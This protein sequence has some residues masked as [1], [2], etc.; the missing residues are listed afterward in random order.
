MAKKKMGRPV[1]EIDKAAFEKFCSIQGTRNEIAVRLGVSHDTLERW[2]KQTYGQTFASVFRDKRTVGFI[3][4]RAAIFDE[5]VNKRN[6]QMLKLLSA[7]LLGYT[8][9]GPINDDEEENEL[10]LDFTRRE[11]I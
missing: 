10:D 2:C 8:D 9:A 11:N 5:G 1:I 6:T 7:N 4:L 3:S